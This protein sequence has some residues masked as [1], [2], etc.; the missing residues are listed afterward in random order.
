MLEQILCFL[1]TSARDCLDEPPV[2]GPL[3]L[4]E[5]YSMIIDAA[6][7]DEIDDF[8]RSEK[9]HGD[10]YIMQSMAEDGKIFRDNLDRAV[11]RVAKYVAK[12][13]E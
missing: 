4:L 12:I 9:K 6:G 13:K 2:Y 10:D 3:R 1:I 5:T 8:F 11:V 7:E